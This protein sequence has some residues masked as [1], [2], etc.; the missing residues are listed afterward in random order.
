[1][2][3][4]F[5]TG[6]VLNEARGNGTP[7][8]T[9]GTRLWRYLAAA[10]WAAGARAS[11]RVRLFGDDEAYRQS[12]SVLGAGRRTETL[13][14]LQRVGA[15]ELG[16]STDATFHV[17]HLALVGG[18]DARDI[19]ATDVERPTTG[20]VQD[21]SSRQ[22]FLGG[23]VEGLAERGGWSGSA[24]IRV[25]SAAN[26]DTR[27]MLGAA[28]T[29]IPD[30]S[31]VVASPRVGVVRQVGKRVAVHAS[32]FRA[33]RT[34]TMNELYRTGQVGQETTLPNAKLVSERATGV[35]GGWTAHVGRVSAQAVYFWTEVNRPVAAVVESTTA[36]TVLQM[37]QNLGQIQSQGAE[38]SLR[39]NEG[40]AVS[41]TVG[42]QY[43]RAVVT[44]FPAAVSLVGRW[45]PDVARESATAQVRLRGGRWG[46]WTVAGRESGRAFDD[47]ANT[48]ILHGFFQLD[49]F[50]E[51]TMGRGFTA[52]VSA[53]NLLDRRADVARTPVLTQGIP[54][55]VQG[56]VR[57]G[58]SGGL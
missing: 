36:T 16:V 5:L 10:D 22:R 4:I 56:G 35:E 15:Q 55:T 54:L 25:D 20:A 31:E 47:S 11:G 21:T 53:Q 41:A 9:N 14:R 28:E 30:R 48:F 51:R 37:R 8:T 19:R 38:V 27:Q 13:S 57:F 18:L 58:W 49:A 50:A 42:Y 46:D 3:R 43:A 12:F 45:I 1:V 26:R 2:G 44:K 23:F 33:F 29:V 24:S 40:R 17:E 6:N 7:L 32:G 39:A 34:P 52:F